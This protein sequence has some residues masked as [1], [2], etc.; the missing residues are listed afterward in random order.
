MASDSVPNP[1]QL[2]SPTKMRDPMPAASNPGTS[3]TPRIAPP[4]P[5][6]SISR[7]APTIGEPRSVLIAA[8][9]PA[10]ADHC[11]RHRGRVTLDKPHRQDAEAAADRDQ[12]RL[13]P[14]HNAQ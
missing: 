13:R 2:S 6:A 14:E 4:I 1:V 3:T 11:D 7:N 12:R 9:L 10:A 5:A 8:K